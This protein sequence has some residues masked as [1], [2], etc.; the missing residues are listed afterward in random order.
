[1]RFFVVNFKE[2]TDSDHFLSKPI[3]VFVSP[4][5]SPHRSGCYTNMGNLGALSSSAPQSSKCAPSQHTIVR[6][7]SFFR[8]DAPRLLVTAAVTA[9]LA[10]PARA[11]SPYSR[12]LFIPL[13]HSLAPSP[14]PFVRKC[15]RSRLAAG[16]V[17]DT[18]R[19]TDRPGWLDHFR[20]PACVYVRT[21]VC[22]CIGDEMT[23]SHSRRQ[24]MVMEMEVM[25]ISTHKKGRKS[26]GEL[27]LANWNLYS[28]GAQMY[29]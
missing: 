21:C 18:D 23:Q 12:R 15:V 7:R 3:V 27:S 26:E 13:P 11:T 8:L 10:S 5:S 1:M 4:P 29:P 19:Q 24:N 6:V 17:C 28:Q 2:P 16:A 14:C 25:E 20:R 22:E 9:S